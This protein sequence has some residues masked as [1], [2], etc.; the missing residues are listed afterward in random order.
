MSKRKSKFKD[1]KSKFE[2]LYKQ[3]QARRNKPF[4]VSPNILQELNIPDTDECV[5]FSHLPLNPNGYP[6]YKGTTV[7]R[8]L[9]DSHKRSIKKC[10]TCHKCNNKLCVN[11]RHLYAGTRRDNWIDFVRSRNVFDYDLFFNVPSFDFKALD[12]KIKHLN[13]PKVGGLEL[14]KFIKKSS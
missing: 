7:I 2:N 10:T 12:R 5:E 11:P 13:A 8:Y 6:L 4:Y 9:R 3:Y 14:V 1:S